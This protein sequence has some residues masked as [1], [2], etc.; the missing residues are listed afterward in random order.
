MQIIEI[1][2]NDIQPY[3][4]NAKKHPEDQI[5][6]IANSIREFGFRQPLVI[7]KDNV[8]VIGHGRLEAAKRLGYDTVPCVRADDLT[9]DQIK[10]LRLAD[11][12]TNESDWD[13]DF[14]DIELD[15]ITDIDM[16][17]FGFE[18]GDDYE[19]PEVERKALTDRFI[20]PPFSVLDTRQG[21]WND[22]KR[23]W[24]D[25]GLKS[26]DGREAEA[27]STSHIAEAYG[28]KAKSGVS[29]FDPVLT[30]TMY[31]WFNVEGGA[32]FD[33][34]A[35]GSVRGIVADKLGYKY[36]G[37]DLRQEQIDAN[38]ENASDM[39][40]APVWY[41]DDSLNADKYIDDDMVDMI[42]TCPPYADLE[43]YSDMP[44]DISNMPYNQFCDIYANILSIANR[45]LKN[46]RFFVVVIGD[47]RDKDG[48]YR[49][50]VDY[51][52]KVLT[53]NGLLLYNDMILAESVGTGA[54]RAPKQFNAMRKVVKVHQNVLVFYKGDIK[55]IKDNYPELDLSEE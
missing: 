45:K 15:D 6:H 49:Q 34:F 7:D 20:V 44:N 16:S 55:H 21:Y 47:V 13:F 38:Y 43:V 42:F 23:E 54:I 52:R 41:C 51:T 5:T 31:R 30:E 22:R 18:L 39:D 53:D 48:A 19:M 11:N 37:I 12:K 40:V 8:L 1:D 4:K 50:L 3:A 9:E 36:T 46:D 35:G 26:T 24:L 17:Q 14:L 29:C 2:V 10:A 25:M 27:L 32:I 33:P 28:K